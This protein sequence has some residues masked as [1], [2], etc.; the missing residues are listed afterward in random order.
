MIVLDT[1]AIIDV[2]LDL[3]PHSRHLAKRIR[4]ESPELATLHLLD[5]EVG[6]V[7]RRWVHRKALPASRAKAALDDLASLPLVR[8]PHLPLAHR[9]FELRDNATFYDALY[10]ALAEGLDATLLTRDAAFGVIRGHTANVEVV[11]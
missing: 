2:L 6:Q 9:A 3:E 5:A 11:A 8:Y 10:L 1:S 4:N 7:L